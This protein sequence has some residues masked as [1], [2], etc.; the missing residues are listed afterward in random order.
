M[1]RLG[2]IGILNRPTSH[3]GRIGESNSVV[4]AA[5]L[6]PVIGAGSAAELMR[7]MKSLLSCVRLGVS[8]EISR[9]GAPGWGRPLRPSSRGWRTLRW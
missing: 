3:C 7:L 1:C 5:S 9:N 2:S 6:R 4:A 8:W